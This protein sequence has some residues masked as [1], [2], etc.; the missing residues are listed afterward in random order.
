MEE[1]IVTLEEQPDTSWKMQAMVIGG[2]VGALVGVGAAYLLSRR[3]E[4]QGSQL[5]ITPQ[6]GLQLGV[7]LA[8]LVRSILKLG[9]G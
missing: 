1:T 6:K 7:L 9:E 3:A 2:V 8:G 4:Q 5:S